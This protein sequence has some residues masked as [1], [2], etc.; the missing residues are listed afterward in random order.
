[1]LWLPRAD[2]S[3]QACV[4]ILASQ[5]VAKAH[6]QELDSCKL[7]QSCTNHAQTPDSFRHQPV[8]L[9]ASG[10]GRLRTVQRQT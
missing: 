10:V 3:Y 2:E 5:P 7:Q 1:M 4:T 9:A 8:K 6:A